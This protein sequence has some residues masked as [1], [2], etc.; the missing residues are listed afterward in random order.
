MFAASEI[1]TTEGTLWGF[2]AMQYHTLVLNRVYVVCVG[3]DSLVGI[4]A[5]GLVASGKVNESMFNPLYW[6][7]TSNL[8]K[9]AR[10]QISDQVV[11]DSARANFRMLFS[12]VQS[13]TYSSDAKW[14]M[15]AVPYSG[16]IFVTA[17]AKNHEFI[18]LG[19]E[20]GI[21]VRDRLRKSCRVA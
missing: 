1:A 7:R 11:I 14:G 20:D 16:R 10:Y 12:E 5:R 6:A 17:S 21:A 3:V 9:Y 19:K 2:V 18:L 13:V 4:T 8:E 15:G